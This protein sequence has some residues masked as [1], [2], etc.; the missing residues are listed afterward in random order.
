MCLEGS[1]PFCDLRCCAHS[2]TVIGGEDTTDP[3]EQQQQQDRQKNLA[4]LLEKVEGCSVGCL[5]CNNN[6][7]MVPCH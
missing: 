1:N 2:L 7:E 3:L 4:F 6:G 5:L